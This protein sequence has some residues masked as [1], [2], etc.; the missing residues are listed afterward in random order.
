MDR[1][2]STARPGRTGSAASAAAT[3]FARWPATT[4][5][6][7]ATAPMSSLPVKPLNNAR[8]VLPAD[9]RAGSKR[10]DSA[11]P[12]RRVN[13]AVDHGRRRIDGEPEPHRPQLMSVG[14]TEGPQPSR[15]A[16]AY[17]YDAAGN[18]R[19]APARGHVEAVLPAADQ[20]ARAREPVGDQPAPRPAIRR[21]GGSQEDER[22]VRGVEGGQA[23]EGNS[24][25]T[26][27][28]DL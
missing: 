16:G 6:S 17:E 13:P 20:T 12:V 14:E 28:R 9:A 26:D 21:V 23:D 5:C 18:D 24:F 22:P 3:R 4:R 10:P 2:Q 8:L 7:A 19:L 27:V 11:P 15:P 1:I 25:A